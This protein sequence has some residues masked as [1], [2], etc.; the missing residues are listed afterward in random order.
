MNTQEISKQQME[1]MR[2]LADTNIK[3]SDAKNI[4][5]KLEET[6]TEYLEEREKK[7][8]KRIQQVLEDSKDVLDMVQ[9]NYYEVTQFNNTV[10]SFADSVM[11]LYGKLVTCLDKFDEKSDLFEKETLRQSNEFNEIKKQIKIDQVSN[12]NE[13]S[14]I[15]K[16]KESLAERERKLESDRGTLDRAIKRL[17]EGKI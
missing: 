12:E 13:K 8:V 5:F 14:N 9:K 6:E 1:G 17:K 3:I 10:S 15:E 2:G 16:A 11:E 4:L 7:A